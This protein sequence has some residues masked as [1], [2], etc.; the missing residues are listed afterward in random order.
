MT[1]VSLSFGALNIDC[2]DP[3]APPTSGGRPSAAPA[4]RPRRQA[5]QAAKLPPVRLT[6]FTDPEG[7]QFDLVTWQPE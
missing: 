7:N 3:A 4:D 6:A 2:A 5:A 1:A